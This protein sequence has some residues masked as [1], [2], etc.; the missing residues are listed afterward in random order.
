V[1]F[2]PPV[3]FEA[4]PGQRSNLAALAPTDLS[5]ARGKG[6]VLPDGIYLTA[7]G[8]RYLASQLLLLIN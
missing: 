4:L 6:M 2:E 5:A 7:A 1:R 3:R 8:Q